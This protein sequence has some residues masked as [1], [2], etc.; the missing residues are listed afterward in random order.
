MPRNADDKTEPHAVR[1]IPGA[2]LTVQTSM[3]ASVRGGAQ[4]T[5]LR[6]LV[7][8]CQFT[9]SEHFCVPGP[10]P[11]PVGVWRGRMVFPQVYVRPEPERR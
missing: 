9:V 4:V 5:C 11:S 7:R 1:L 8:I 10:V 3:S 6:C 2:Q